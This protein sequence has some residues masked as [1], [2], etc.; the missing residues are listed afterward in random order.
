MKS[1]YEENDKTDKLIVKIILEIT[2]KEPELSQVELEYKVKEALKFLRDLPGFATLDALRCNVSALLAEKLYPTVPH[3]SEH[4]QAIVR[5][6]TRHVELCTTHAAGAPLPDIVRRIVALYALAS[7]LPPELSAEEVHEAILATYPH[8]KE[9]RPPLPQVVYAFIS[10]ELMYLRHAAYCHSV[11]YVKGA[12]TTAYMEAKGL[13]CIRADLLEVMIWKLLGEKFLEKL[14][15]PVGQR[16]EEE[17]AGILIDNPKKGFSDVVYE[18]IQFFKRVK[19]LALCK[20]WDEIERKVHCWTLQ[21]DL[22]CRFLHL[23][24]DSLLIKLIREKVKDGLTHQALVGETTLCFLR[25]YPELTI[26]LPQL[27]RR[28]WT[29]YKY[30]WYALLARAEESSL[31]R[32]I[33][34][35]GDR[36]RLEEIVRRSLPLF[37]LPEEKTAQDNKRDA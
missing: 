2:A 33:Q 12:I 37:S 13:P 18:T 28:I 31:D 30:A 17:I 20:K 29:C 26:Y 34:W 1:P 32:L 8:V 14:P 21:G 16:I 23:D 11:D 9:D 19:E 3:S 24:A 35:H 5:F 15:Y 10:A 7:G 6:I 36:G 27:T 4:T 22:L 25:A